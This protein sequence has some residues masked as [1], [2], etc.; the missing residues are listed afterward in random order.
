M[1][2]VSLPLAP[3]SGKLLTLDTFNYVIIGVAY[4]IVVDSYHRLWT[5]STSFNEF[6]EF[7]CHSF[8]ACWELSQLVVCPLLWLHRIS[9][10]VLILSFD[11]LTTQGWHMIIIGLNL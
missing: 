8:R 9:L 1:R 4:F 2:L 5:M 3:H 11:T 7:I 6:H 10:E